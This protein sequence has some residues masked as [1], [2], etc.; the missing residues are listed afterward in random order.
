MITFSI[1]R[2]SDVYGE[3]KPLLEEHYVE[4]STHVAHGVPLKPRT[5]VYEDRQAD[6]SLMIVVGREAGDIVSYFFCFIASALHYE[7]CLTCS[8]D[9]FYVKPD[10]RKGRLGIRMFRFVEDELR[11]RGVVR[12]AV[13]SKID[14]DASALFK[15]LGFEPV[16]TTHEKW[17]GE[18]SW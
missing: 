16:E 8:P 18:K 14:H 15:Y 5:Q 7:T 13:G 9:I 2:F 3:M 12:W 17:L 11:R 10:R 4:I 6:G 1:E